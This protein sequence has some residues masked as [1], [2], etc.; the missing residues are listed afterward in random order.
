MKKLIT[1]IKRLALALCLATPIVSWAA[2]PTPVAVWDGNFS[3]SELTKFSGYELVDWNETHGEN[4]SS[5]RIDRANQGLMFNAENGVSAVTVLVRYSNLWAGSN[6]R[7]LFST[8]VSDNYQGT[9]TAVRYGSGGYLNGMW[10]TS[11]YGTAAGQPSS[12][13]VMAFTYKGPDGTGA[14]TY[15]YGGADASSLALLWGNSALKSK[16]D[17]SVYS[18][19]IGGF[20][21]GTSVSGYE[22]AQGMN[23]EAVAVFDSVIPLADLKE[24]V[25]PSEVSFTVTENTSV[26]SLNTQIAGTASGTSKVT[27]DVADGVTIDVD[28]AF[29]ST[30]PV[31]IESAG[32]VTLSAASQPDLS[33]V[34]FKV[35]GALLR[36][37]LEPGVVGFNFYKNKGNDTTGALA[38]GT[39]Y[40]NAADKKGT[41]TDLF[42]DGLSVISW[43][44]STL[45]SQGD[46]GEEGTLLN[47]YLDD[48][49]LN[50]NGA[51]VYLTNI[52]YETYDV[53]IYAASDTA[54]ANFLAK[55]VNGTTY[56]WDSTTGSVVE[57]NA[58]WGKA[59]LNTPVYG[60]NALRIKNLTG[61]LTI[62]GTAKSGT[63][64]GGISAIQIMPPDT[65]D[66][67]RTY[68]L[69]LDGTATTW[70][71]GTWTLNDQAVEAPTAGYVEIVASASTEVTVDAAVSIASLTIKGA[72]DAVVTIST[73]GEE[74]SSFSAIGA[75]IESGVFKQGVA[76]SVTGFITVE[77]GGTFDMN[78]LAVGATLNIAGAG[79]GNWPWALTSSSGAIAID[80]V[81][82]T[83]DATIGGT[84]QITLGKDWA[85]SETYLNTY[86][87][88]KD[89]TGAL[90]CRNVN[91]IGTGAIDLR[92]GTT[93]F[94]Q[95]TSLDGSE[96][97]VSGRSTIVT[98]RDGA[99][100]VNNAG[101]R[102]R[103]NTLNVESGATVTTTA[104][105]WFAVT[106]AFNGT[107]D[108]TKLEFVDGAEVT[109]TGD[110]TVATLVC[111][112][113]SLATADSA[114]VTVSDTVDASGT[115][116]VGA[117]VT[118]AFTGEGDVTATLSY[119]A[120][121]S[122]TAST[123]LD[124]TQASN[125]KGTVV[126]DYAI[127]GGNS[128]SV[129]QPGK[130]GNANSTVCLGK[131]ATDIF[132]SVRDKSNFGNID[133][134]L[135]FKG[136]VSL[137]NG[138]GGDTKVTT[139]PQLGADE[140]VTFTTRQ[141]AND[142]NGTTYYTITALKD[143]AGTIAL[144]DRTAV[145]VGNVVLNELPEKGALVVK[146]TT[147]TSSVKG[148]ITGSVT[149]GETTVPLV[150]GTVGEETGLMRPS[151][152]TVT[153]PVVANTTFAVTVGGE[154]AQP[155][156]EGGNVF[157]V[158]AG[159]AVVVTYTGVEGYKVNGGSYVVNI[160]AT[161]DTTI[162]TSSM[163][164][165]EYVAWIYDEN[166]D[167]LGN[168]YTTPM[169]AVFAFSNGTGNSI[170]FKTEL[171]Q[172]YHEALIAG[173]SYDETTFTYTRLPTVATITSGTL[174]HKYTSIAAALA[175]AFEGAEIVL[176]ASV[177]ESV[178]YT[179]ENA[180]TID[181]NGQTWSFDD[182]KNWAAFIN[183]G[184][185]VTFKDSAGEGKIVGGGKFCVW[186]RTGSLVIESGTY[187]NDSNDNYAVYVGT[188]DEGL[189][190]LP[191]P[192]VT[193]TGGA[194]VNL[195]T[196]EYVHKPGSG[197]HSLNLNVKNY[198]ANDTKMATTLIQV[199]GGSFTWDPALGDDNMGGTF[200][201]AGYQSKETSTGVWT[202]TEKKGIDPTASFPE[203][204]EV[205]PTAE[206]IAAAGSAE[207]AV[208]AKIEVKVPDMMPGADLTPAD[209]VDAATYKTYFN[210]KV[211]ET[212]SGV[213]EVVLE[214]GNELKSEV[215]LPATATVGEET[216]TLTEEVL[217]AALS[218]AEEAEA[219]IPA[220]AG[221]YYWMQASN[222]L[223]FNES[224]SGTTYGDRVLST[225]STVT[226]KKP[227]VLPTGNAVFFRVR[228]GIIPGN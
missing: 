211:T 133:T 88:T 138:W 22:A 227:E 141:G 94:T 206:E 50:G 15:L 213:Y 199:S 119:A 170:R 32:T 153:V 43:N 184:A 92:G 75:T 121:P 163:V 30:I 10:G 57:G 8:S 218:D 102:L 186:A 164:V 86:T 187:E 82:L 136:N 20:V 147:G 212:S 195:N 13:G 148:T 53:I 140:G 196:E 29:S 207:E 72:E 124:F 74:G 188:N 217:A 114:I 160:T 100:L 214:P 190:E 21:D 194:F 3:A 120:D 55:T 223:E 27:F 144:S 118:P 177:T 176:A 17:T 79:A 36:S 42:A 106:E 180:V 143:F 128:G 127:T 110:L 108:T 40:A 77:D 99:T 151:T 5:V 135:Y 193:I 64:R 76:S 200:V 109:L 185:T 96:T 129:F 202:V 104:T 116:A 47:G 189:G 19:G 209:V 183:N 62:Y 39:W 203:P 149:V 113:L 221:I 145:T 204:L 34:T 48:G 111:G 132:L 105:G 91:T 2:A 4:N 117:G 107:C 182:A 126:L 142:S 172:S 168:P 219:T 93:T 61:A 60:V 161:E 81:T 73:D 38:T 226:V 137:R 95:W 9:R 49:S 210:Y 16:D 165:N 197:W 46:Y 26:S 70:S 224:S 225:G 222:S 23:I 125:W 122:P 44:C 56:T 157:T 215:V 152:V 146:A 90:V 173:C 59:A 35:R 159:S 66:N 25:W 18:V 1:R 37:W 166:G 228:A 33:G 201:A 220:V 131:G 67:I 12:S 191:A 54:T 174:T 179:G 208:I 198:D 7:V 41:S 31:I 156:T 11:D 71:E 123:A 51:E 68:K 205:T 101:R 69:T 80:S 98:V 89:G 178:T 112:G 130:Y 175:E 65:P 85:G 6:H 171:E 83:A 169:T 28:S 154:S 150:F 78:G 14:G 167:L 97:V 158:D 58:A 52:P 45:Y 192:T 155:D 115:I 87:L 162:D 216:F 103:M 181:L 84:N 139:I 134:K 63:P 24:Y